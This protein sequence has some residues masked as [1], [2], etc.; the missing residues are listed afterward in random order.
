MKIRKA[1]ITVALAAAITGAATTPALAATATAA[2]T[3][4]VG[5]DVGGGLLTRQWLHVGEV[6]NLQGTGGRITGYRV[7]AVH[8]DGESYYATVW[9]RLQTNSGSVV[10]FTTAN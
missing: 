6:I 4:T 5:H 3:P 2:H 8:R 9:P 1:V 10:L 7:T